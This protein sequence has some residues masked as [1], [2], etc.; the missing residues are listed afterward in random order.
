[1]VLFVIFLNFIDKG[2]VS[3]FQNLRTIRNYARTGRKKEK[4]CVNG[5]GTGRCSSTSIIVLLCTWGT[6][7]GNV[8]FNYDMGE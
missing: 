2:I 6:E 1:M 3:T 4:K 5:P 8:K 7:E